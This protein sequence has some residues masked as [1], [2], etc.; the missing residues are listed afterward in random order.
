MLDWCLIS[1][2]ISD[3]A[4]WH[5]MAAKTLPHLSC[6]LPLPRMLKSVILSL[7][8]AFSTAE[9]YTA[10]L[11]A[12]FLLA[13]DS[14][15]SL[16]VTATFIGSSGAASVDELL[17][18]DDQGLQVFNSTDLSVSTAPVTLITYPRPRFRQRQSSLAQRGITRLATLLSCLLT[19]DPSASR[20]APRH[21]S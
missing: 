2:G 18:S 21:R 12:D 7:L 8:L 9:D 10:S 16:N 20:G 11:G 6:S 1:P 5:E 19:V 4:R 14:G 13:A 15:P 3:L 17:Y